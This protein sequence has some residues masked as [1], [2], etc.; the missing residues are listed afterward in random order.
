M[1]SNNPPSLGFG[2]V[3]SCRT[4]PGNKKGGLSAHPI[5]TPTL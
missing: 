2:A 3:I 4:A 5:E 1:M